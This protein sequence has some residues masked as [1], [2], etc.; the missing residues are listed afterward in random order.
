LAIENPT[1][2]AI[3]KSGENVVPNKVQIKIGDY[4]IAEQNMV[5][6]DYNEKMVKKYI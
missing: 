1:F 2:F 3:E 6:K 5:A 4:L